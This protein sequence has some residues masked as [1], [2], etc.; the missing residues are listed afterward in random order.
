MIKRL[1]FLLFIN[2]AYI[3]AQPSEKLFKEDFGRLGFEFGYKINEV[4]NENGNPRLVWEVSNS[5]Y[6]GL[7]YSIHQIRAWNFKVGLRY[8]QFDWSEELYYLS[9]TRSFSS[10]A[11]LGPMELIEIPLE[12]EYFFFHSNKFYF[13]LISGL[14]VTLNPY[15]YEK[16]KGG[17]ASIIGTDT[18]YYFD[19]YFES[20]K[21]PVYFGI[22]IGASVSYNANLFLIKLTPRIHIQLEDYIYNGTVVVFD[23]GRM[24]EAN[25]Q[26]TGSYVG[27]DITIH[28]YKFFKKAKYT[29]D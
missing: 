2:P 28:P 7:T 12:A 29:R 23:N 5:R 17:G 15:G 21:D 11:G 27:L 24:P 13:S 8:A 3:N 20:H 18:L 14:E 4:K 19:H 10:N 6:L 26:L 22:N 1:L 25:T 16:F 9:S